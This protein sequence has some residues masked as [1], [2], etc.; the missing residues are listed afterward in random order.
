[1]KSSEAMSFLSGS[2]ADFVA[3]LY[4]RYAADPTS[5][6]PSWRDFFSG[7][8]DDAKGI[9]SEMRGASWSETP[10]SRVI[11][12]GHAPQNVVAF[13][14]PAHHAANDAVNKRDILDSLRAIMLIRAWRV[15]G[16]LAANLDP[17]GLTPVGRH[18][19]LDPATYGFGEADI[20]RPVFIDGVLGL[21]QATVRQ[22]IDALKRIYGGSVGVEFM[23][24][25]DPA[26]K[27]WIQERVEAWRDAPPLDAE[28]R[29]L[30]LQSLTEAEAFEKFLQVKFPG[31]KRFGID[32]GESMMPA[33]KTIISRGADLGLQEVAIGMPHRG[34]LNVL[35]NLLQKPF[36]A[37]FAEFQG[38]SAYP[39]S[40][41]G[42]GD[43]KYHMGMSIDR[44]LDGKMVH[45]TLSSNPS[46]LEAVDP[47]VVGRVRAKQQ[48]RSGS[49]T[50]STLARTQVMGLLLHGDAAFAGQ[51]MVAET[52][53]LS[54]LQGYCTG[55][56]MHFV[57]NNQVGFTTSP[58]YSRSGV[59]CTDVA[60]MIQ[61]PIFHVNADDV[62]AVVRV[63]RLA[64][65]FRQTFLKDV[66]IDMV[67]Y[68][69]YGHNESDEPAFTQPK[70]YRKIRAQQTTREIYANKLAAE[71]CMTLEESDAANA[72]FMA[73]L[74]RDFQAASS[75][76]PVRADWLEGKWK[77]LEAALGGEEDGDTGVAADTL[78]EIG[79][80]LARVPEG[81]NIN[82]KI[83]RQLEAKR[84]MMDTGRDIDWATAEALAFGSLAVEGTHV[85]LSG[86]DCGRGTFSQRHSVFYDQETEQR[87][88][89]LNHLRPQQASYEVHDS[90]LSEAAVMGFDYGFS[91]VEPKAL[92]CWE[93]QFG[94][95][96][97]GAQVMIDQCIS[98]A[99]AKWL[100]MSGFVLLLPHGY[101]GQGPEHS[102]ARLE[103]YL[104]LCGQNNWQVANCST[105]AN[106]FHILRRQV[107]RNF[108]KPLVLMTPKSLLRHKMCVS[109]LAEMAEGTCFRRVI[110][111]TDAAIAGN[112]NVRRVVLCCG[113]VYYDLAAARAERRI[114]DVAIV[115]LEQLY[116][117][118]S[119]QLGE[120]LAAWPD[121][122]VV[123]CQEEPENMGAWMFADRRIEAALA[124]VS[125]RAGRP[126]YVGRPESA[127]TAVGSLKKHNKE[128]AA[129]VDE[130]LT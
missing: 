96:A 31:T 70:M 80:G 36:V 106:Y 120:I 34:R 111:E 53:M 50:P 8:R 28:T 90:P 98:S 13:P 116:P 33:L 126:R 100:R 67:C 78:R 108:R 97:N 88:V 66:V 87:H 51:G 54:E 129:L 130:A 38:V 84:T 3:E 56:T 41:K 74:E 114:T 71:G 76:V 9:I 75:Y 92:V 101:E 39:D 32:G 11:A 123:W 15:C 37:M 124:S 14:Q 57:V 107:R 49:M 44:E 40:I 79:H 10:L 63:A 95:F 29:R 42:S 81:F 62:D 5:V 7:L 48:Q 35:T 46:H 77:G 6:D 128:Q 25:Q 1:M 64:A 47:I 105:P 12:G 30:T 18:P 109:E 117:F 22:I 89:P 52:L 73:K 26:Q 19:E 94:D 55:G 85:R 4:A 110:G 122:E 93:G 102:S 43:V 103:R 16:H 125:H 112:R 17:L 104:Q 72:E 113:K 121:A 86:Q 91:M 115:R 45:L 119:A 58:S 99:E 21:E 24:I 69:R 127:A 2:N 82:P 20:D 61:A 27:S 68:R 65:E 83:A 59:Y 60:K 23:H 118:P